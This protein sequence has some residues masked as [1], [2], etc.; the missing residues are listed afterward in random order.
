[1][2]T[3]HTEIACYLSYVTQAINLNLIPLFF[4]IFQNDYSVSTAKLSVI[5]FL[6]F[7]LQI[8][9]DSFLAYMGEKVN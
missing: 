4:V 2:K 1:M 6:T 8:S 3:K 5:V 9:I 7:A